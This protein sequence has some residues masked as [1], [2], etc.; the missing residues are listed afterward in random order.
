MQSIHGEMMGELPD[1][2]ALGDS[3]RAAAF[4]W[5][6]K[7]L[8]TARLHDQFIFL[9]IALEILCDENGDRVSEPYVGPCQHEIPNCPQ[10]GRA[11]TRMVRG[12]TLRSFLESLGVETA[13]AKKLWQMR[14]LMHGA[15]PFD[16]RK[17]NELGTLIQPL[18]A[19]TAIGL[20][21]LL[22]K[23]AGDPPIIESS[24]L[25]VRPAAAVAATGKISQKD[26]E[27]L[28]GSL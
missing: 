7:S 19:A 20:K 27:P 4:R 10:C 26:L 5:F 9:W 3:R 28:A 6:V 14:Q 23:A 15:I 21:S 1:I 12:K 13:E 17:V 16:S 2:A 8:E 24:G 11:T 25:S 22:G 18:R